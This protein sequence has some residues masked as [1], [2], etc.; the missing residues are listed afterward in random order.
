MSRGVYWSAILASWS[1]S[2]VPPIFSVNA[3]SIVKNLL[4]P[5]V[6]VV[7]VLVAIAFGV[8]ILGFIFLV[9]QGALRWVVGG[10][11]GR[12][13]AVQTFMRAAEVLAIIPVMFFISSVLRSM[14]V[15]QLTAV[16]DIL[17][18]LLQRGWSI[19]MSSL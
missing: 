2:P 14:G 10:S 1:T 3:E 5:F 8:G 18:K 13:M 4:S 9:L 11:F 7:A 15:S 17:E 12:S 19:I 16:A 6:D